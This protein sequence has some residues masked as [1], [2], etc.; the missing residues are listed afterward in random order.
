M[1]KKEWVNLTST[2]WM[3]KLM[4]TLIKTIAGILLMNI[5]KR[6]AYVLIKLILTIPLLILFLSLWR[7]SKSNINLLKTSWTVKKKFN[8]TRVKQRILSRLINLVN[9]CRRK[10]FPLTDSVVDSE[11]NNAQKVTK[12]LFLNLCNIL[13]FNLVSS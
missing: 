5:S 3:S 9:L 4:T 13:S 11:I 8:I 1:L 6:M 12:T 7:T 2:G 10:K